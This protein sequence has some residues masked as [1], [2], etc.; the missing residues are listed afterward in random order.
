MYGYL[1]VSSDDG[2]FETDIA[3]RKRGI[4]RCLL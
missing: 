3:S 1:I 2:L 4:Q